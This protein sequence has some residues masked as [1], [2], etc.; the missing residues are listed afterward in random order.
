[1]WMLKSNL[2]PLREPTVLLTGPS[3]TELQILLELEI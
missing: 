1:M 3:P 2:G